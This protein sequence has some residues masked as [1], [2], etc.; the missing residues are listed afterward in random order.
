VII[1]AP[2]LPIHMAVLWFLQSL[3]AGT[4]TTFSKTAGEV[5]DVREH[6]V[7]CVRLAIAFPE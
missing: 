6:Y 2:A 4:V 7:Q 3:F 5:A 1:S